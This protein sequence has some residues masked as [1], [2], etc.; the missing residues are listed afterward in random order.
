MFPSWLSVVKFFKK[1]KNQNKNYRNGQ[2]NM[3]AVCDDQG[4]WYLAGGFCVLLKPFDIDLE[5]CGVDENGWNG[6][7]Q[8]TIDGNGAITFNPGDVLLD[9][10]EFTFAGNI[11]NL[12]GVPYQ[13]IRSRSIKSDNKNV[14]LVEMTSRRII[15]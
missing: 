13:S 8:A 9:N 2:V 7:I 14:Q 5:L 10:N 4:Q 6:I 12:S 15:I 3:N 11:E 1:K